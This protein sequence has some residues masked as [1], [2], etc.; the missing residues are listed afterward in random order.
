MGESVV[1]E[2]VYNNNL[3]NIIHFRNSNFFIPLRNDRHAVLSQLF[4]DWSSFSCDGVSSSQH[5]Y[6]SCSS[7][8]QTY[9][10]SIS[11]IKK[12]KLFAHFFLGLIVIEHALFSFGLFGSLMQQHFIEVLFRSQQVLLIDIERR[13]VRSI[14]FGMGG[15]FWH[16]PWDGAALN[17]NAATAALFDLVKNNLPVSEKEVKIQCHPTTTER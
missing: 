4:K 7:N 5:P 3:K 17:R 1:R 10:C 9:R 8:H 13:F 11:S 14:S 16:R 6:S 2:I 15:L 12:E